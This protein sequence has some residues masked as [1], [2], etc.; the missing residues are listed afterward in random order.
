MKH[1]IYILQNLVNLKIYV[2]QTN[3]PIRRKS[4]HKKDA[5]VAL[6]QRPLYKSIRKHG[7][8]NFKFQIVEEIDELDCDEAEIF[9]IQ[10]FRSCDMN[11]GYNL[12]GGG[13]KNK[14]ISNETKKKKSIASKKNYNEETKIRL[15]NSK[16]TPEA[17]K[18]ASNA[19][20]GDKNPRA[21]LNTEKVL[22][23]RNLWSLGTHSLDQLSKMFNTPKV[24]IHHV[25]SRYTWKHI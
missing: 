17:L 15:A 9:W 10:F 2:G 23:I 8:K 25:I 13:R 22:E 4:G 18:N 6:L 7:W 24:T 19:S 12:D 21:K 11:Y 1:Y 3:N 20:I 5:F 14:I 16:K